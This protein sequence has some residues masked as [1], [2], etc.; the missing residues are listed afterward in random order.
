MSNSLTINTPNIVQQNTP[1]RNV[2]SGSTA[3]PDYSVK[4]TPQDLT[5]A[6]KAQA[7]ANIGAAAEGQGGGGDAT[8]LDKYWTLYPEGDTTITAYAGNITKVWMDGYE[9]T[10]SEGV[11]TVYKGSTV[12]IE[13]AA[14]TSFVFGNTTDPIWLW[15]PAGINVNEPIHGTFYNVNLVNRNG[16]GQ[17]IN[18]SGKVWLLNNKLSNS[19]FTLTTETTV[20]YCPRVYLSDTEIDVTGLDVTAPAMNECPV[21]FYVPA[22]RFYE[23]KTKLNTKYG[24]EW[25]NTFML[26]VIQ[27]QTIAQNEHTLEVIHCEADNA[28]NS[29]IIYSEENTDLTLSGIET[30]WFK[31]IIFG[32]ERNGRFEETNFNL[33]WREDSAGKLNSESYTIKI[34][35]GKNV[36]VVNHYDRNDVLLPTFS[37][38][39]TTPVWLYAKNCSANPIITGYSSVGSVDLMN[40]VL[41]NVVNDSF[42][43]QGEGNTFIFNKNNNTSNFGFYLTTRNKVIFTDDSMDGVNRGGQITSASDVLTTIYCPMGRYNELVQRYETVYAEAIQ[44][45]MD[46]TWI[47]DH[48]VKYITLYNEDYKIKVVTADI[49]PLTM[50]DANGNTIDGD[51]VAQNVTI[52][53]AV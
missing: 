25:T 19:L 17:N 23:L 45:G 14:N 39:N 44:Q 20:T 7:R 37:L 10:A 52:T 53:P 26:H 40:V 50:T 15:S 30:Q 29:I 34:V 36:I 51:F 41:L 5:D 11:Y 4:Y 49:L 48:I 16:G 32:V 13:A 27:Y 9:R 47:T 21:I 6:Q 33:G 46:I 8:D 22:S 38:N 24:G 35:R 43:Y 18:F 3:E 28:F 31:G 12:R 1:L 42:G 2:P